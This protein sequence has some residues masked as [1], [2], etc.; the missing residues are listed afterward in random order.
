M[1][2][3]RSYRKEP[4]EFMV[5]SCN[6]FKTRK[7]R[8]CLPKGH[9]FWV[10][11]KKSRCSTHRTYRRPITPDTR[12][13]TAGQGEP[14]LHGTLPARYCHLQ[15]HS[16][17]RLVL[18]GRALKVSNN[19]SLRHQILHFVLKPVSQ[20]TAEYEIHSHPTVI[21]FILPVHPLESVILPQTSPPLTHTF[22]APSPSLPNT[23]PT[24]QIRVLLNL[25][26]YPAVL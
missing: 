16:C 2:T 18:R 11:A 9:S 1:G 7:L 5:V 20:Y 14:T 22:K 4:P 25:L 3:M 24:L 23:P 10:R 17:K 13:S 8:K 12:T 19:L 26:L 6:I 15:G 21:M